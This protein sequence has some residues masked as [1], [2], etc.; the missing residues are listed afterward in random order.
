MINQ[1]PYLSHQHE[2]LKDA[3][4]EG[5]VLA[6]QT[7]GDIHTDY[8]IKRSKAMPPAAFPRYSEY[9]P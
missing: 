1:I 2:T 5:L 8:I 6:E 9:E 4:T 7:L 3:I